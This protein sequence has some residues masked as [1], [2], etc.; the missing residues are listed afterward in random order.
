MDPLEGPGWSF[1]DVEGVS[2]KELLTEEDWGSEDSFWWSAPS[3][4]EGEADEDSSNER[5][6]G[7]GDGDREDEDEDHDDR[8]NSDRGGGGEE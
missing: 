2:G 6:S 7:G 3:E 8:D 4:G 1:M 5:D